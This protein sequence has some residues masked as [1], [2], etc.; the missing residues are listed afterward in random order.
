V[1]RCACAGFD[2]LLLRLLRSNG[3]QLELQGIQAMLLLFLLVGLL[4]I[5]IALQ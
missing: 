2:I 5:I 3:R 1:L 4:L